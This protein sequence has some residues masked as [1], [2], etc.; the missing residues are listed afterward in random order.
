VRTIRAFLLRLGGLFNKGRRDRELAEEIESNLQLHIDDNIR[1][2]MSPEDARRDALLKFG[3]VESAKEAYRDRRSLPLLEDSIQDIRFALRMLARRPGFAT[4]VILTL[5]LGIGAN[6]AMFSIIHA[7]ILR[8]LPYK[9]ADRLVV[10]FASPPGQEQITK[11]FASYRSFQ[12]WRR[13]SQSFEQLEACSWVAQA[14]QVL[15]WQGTAQRVM[16]VPV[17]SG[18]FSLLGV[19]AANGRTFENSDLKTGCSVILSHGFWQNWL[20]A[21]P[22]IVGSGL[23]LDDQACT[24]VGI[25]PKEFEFYPRQADLWTLITPSSA[26]ERQP[27][28][29][30]IGVFGRLKPGVN[31][32]SAQAELAVLH[33]E[34]VRNAPP[35]HSGWGQFAPVVSELQEEF[36]WLAGRSLRT[37]LVVLFGAVVC[38]LL[39]ACVNVASLQMARASERERELALRAALG[40]GRSRLIR[41]LITESIMLA[42]L[43]AVLGALLAVAIVRWFRSANPVELPPGNSVIINWQA[44]IFTAGVAT[45]AGLLSGLMPA[46]KASRIDLNEAL[47][48]TSRGGASGALANRATKLLISAEVALSLTLLTGAGLL[49]QS[50]ARL[51]SVDLGF[52]TDHLLT[53]QLSLPA[54]S[55][56]RQA[57]RAAF[58]DNLASRLSALPGVEAAAIS[59]TGGFHLPLTVAGRP[60]PP[61][62]EV[63]DISLEQVSA[64]YLTTM[65]IP[66]LRGR[67][68]ERGD[69]EDSQPVAV[70]NE[71]LA[72]KYFPNEDPLGRQIKLGSS[73]TDPWLTIVGVAG[74]VKGIILSNEMA[75]E[76][77]PLVYLPLNQSA[78]EGVQIRLRAN[79]NATGLAAALQGAVSA[80]D[81]GAPVYGVKTMEQQI[82][83][84]L[85]HP[86]FR[87][88]L[89]GSFAGLA[90]LLTAIG[91][92]GMLS[93]SVSH[94]TREIGIRMALGAERED[95]LRMVIR[96]G[97][98]LMLAGAVIGV[99]AALSVTRLLTSMLYGVKPTDP[100]TLVAVLLMLG[101]VVV[102]ASYFPAR[103]ATKVDPMVVLRDE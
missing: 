86:R 14:G 43:G 98:V 36:T 74:N 54:S 31:R 1:A 103:R 50:I 8:P 67:P 20:G 4:I 27:L 72:Q 10:V 77:S 76:T 73:D 40:S 56:S 101:G 33:Q 70:I 64:G 24:V 11:V 12:E 16:S 97:L 95:V 17:T 48:E 55:Y 26:F 15:I 45:L 80:L 90:L 9:D 88:I 41:Q 79:N 42:M 69:R 100:V 62:N 93:E 25:M 68:F 96:Q 92:Y 52:R 63:N 82:S 57:Q 61:R 83:E 59:S 58:Y 78:G 75:Y 81:R 65:G 19:Q 2:G 89:L 23:R 102:L 99:A 47:K 6:T 53:A 3:G 60:D 22:D 51:S 39:I 21:S 5:A 71:A 30:G 85:A 94:R 37:G 32:T 7:V 84:D 46:F 87:A 66:L 44:L 38:V 29:A 91:I 35:E 18:F 13:H 28:Q 49:I 34:V